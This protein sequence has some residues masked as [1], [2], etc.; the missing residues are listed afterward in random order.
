MAYLLACAAACL[1]AVQ[2]T[3]EHANVNS[4]WEALGSSVEEKQD[5]PVNSRGTRHASGVRTAD[6]AN[7][8]RAAPAT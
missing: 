6:A 7:P 2:L 5:L 4:S 3:G 1:S 8:L